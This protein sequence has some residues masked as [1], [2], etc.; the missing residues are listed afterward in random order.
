MATPIK[1]LVREAA[2]S[3]TDIA[4]EADLSFPTVSKVVN[5]KPVSSLSVSKV[6][7]VLGIRLGRHIDLDSVTGVKIG[8][9]D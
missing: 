2:M 9:S 8:D 7:R 1:K 3:L 4:K 5:G 6:L